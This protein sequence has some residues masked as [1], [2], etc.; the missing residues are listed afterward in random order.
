MGEKI[1]RSDHGLSYP[2]R[3]YDDFPSPGRAYLYMT[4]GPLS[5]SSLYN[6]RINSSFLVKQRVL[7][8]SRQV[9]SFCLRDSILFLMRH[10]AF[11]FHVY[12]SIAISKLQMSSC[13]PVSFPFPLPPCPSMPFFLHSLGELVT[14]TRLFGFACAR[15]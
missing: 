10:S 15:S 2:V 14:A 11:P 4:M 5:I 3:Y 8:C 7:I 1:R 9:F 6:V 12:Y 13:F